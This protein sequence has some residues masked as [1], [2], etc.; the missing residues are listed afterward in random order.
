M[1]WTDGVAL[2]ASSTPPAVLARL[3]A[4]TRQVMCDADTLK[5]LR[6][7]PN[8]P[9]LDMTPEALK[10]QMAIDT[11]FWDKAQSELAP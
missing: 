6:A 3:Q 7:Q 9:W 2:F 1:D 4:V 5:L 10:A 11:V 8:Q